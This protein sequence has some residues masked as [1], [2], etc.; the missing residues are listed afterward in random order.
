MLP[1]T[2]SNKMKNIDIAREKILND[3]QK[4]VLNIIYEDDIKNAQERN[5]VIAYFKEAM[6][7]A[8]KWDI[9][10]LG[11]YE[12]NFNME[13][14]R[15]NP[16]YRSLIM[17]EVYWKKRLANWSGKPYSEIELGRDIYE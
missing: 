11:E 6:K 2:R 4:A 8:K 13:E 3:M 7:L 14:I 15:I 12:G 1:L 10:D 9:F 17:Q 5:E 16:E